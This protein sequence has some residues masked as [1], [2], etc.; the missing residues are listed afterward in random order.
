MPDFLDPDGMVDCFPPWV[1]EDRGWYD[2]SG[3][4][5]AERTR[6]ALR[7]V[8]RSWNEHLRRYPHRFVRITDVMHQIVPEKYL[9][10]AKRISFDDHHGES[11]ETCLERFEEFANDEIIYDDACRLILKR[12]KPLE[13]AQILDLRITSCLSV[14]EYVSVET[15]P[16]LLRVHTEDVVLQTETIM[17]I[18]ESFSSFR[19]M[20]TR[21][22]W[23][24]DGIFSLRSSTLTTLHLGICISSPTMFTSETLHLPA[25][26]HLYIEES[27]YDGPNG[28]DEPSWIS[29][30][31][32]IGRELR[33]LWLP[34]EPD[35][36]LEE[37]PGEIWKLCPKLED[38]FTFDS[39]PTIPPPVGHPI[40][41]LGIPEFLVRHDRPLEGA[42]PDWPGLRTVRID[43]T[44]HFWT[45]YS[46]G[47]LTSSQMEWLN[48]RCICLEDSKGESLTN[49]LA[50]TKL[51]EDR[52]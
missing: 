33:S 4:Y 34:L 10:T 49:Y 6:N 15:F 12:L 3:Y 26:E 46:H 45:S 28:Y 38:L 13:N 22:P 41:T 44:W 42:L 37:V 30:V 51:K 2:Y 20:Y 32:I 17:G 18:I 23:Y 8:C 52:S 24:L 16:N 21:L 29:L 39:P 25:L 11:C 36:T 14:E 9:K 31:R 48:S 35:C 5:E 27:Y 1:I 19:H 43:S 47:S 7:R 50:R 40:H